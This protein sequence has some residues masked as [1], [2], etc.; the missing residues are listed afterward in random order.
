[1]SAIK[2]DFINNLTHE[3]KTPIATISIAGD[4]LNKE[5][6][7]T[8]EERR[9]KYLSI[10]KTENER[11]KNHVNQILQISNIEK[12]DIF[13]NIDNINIHTLIEK[14]LNNFEIIIKE[15]E[16]VFLKDFRAE[17]PI[18]KIDE[19]HFYNVLSNLIDN[20]IKYTTNKPII[21]IETYNN[22][23]AFII[24]LSDNGIG[25]PKEH[26][27]HVFK[28]FYRVPTGN[29]HNIKGF[30]LGLY[31]VKTILKAMKA[32]IKIKSEPHKGTTFTIIIAV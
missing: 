25:I 1:M 15:K 8:D 3:F 23:G 7:I 26:I 12:G 30:G 19:T 28:Q 18:A 32:D 16:G 20:S 22:E 13:L 27:N 14:L 10:I 31:Y 9:Q 21:S 29:I 6:V 5:I 4:M 2:A 17:S 24:E 11:L